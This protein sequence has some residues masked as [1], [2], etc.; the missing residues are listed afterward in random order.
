MIGIYDTTRAYRW[1]GEME[2]AG[3]GPHEGLRMPGSPLLVVANGGIHTHPDSARD[4]LNSATMEPSLA[5]ID[6]RD[7]RL[8]GL[9][10]LP[11][12]LHQVSIRHL[13]CADDGVVWFAGQYEGDSPFIHGLA[14]SLSV[15]EST[16]SFQAGQ[17]RQGLR[18][19]DVPADLQIRMSHYLSSVA[20]AGH[21]VVFTSAPGGLAFRVDRA[22]GL[23]EE[24]LSILDCSG[25]AA[26]PAE[27]GSDAGWYTL[28]SGALVTSGTGGI[29]RVSDDGIYSLAMH[30]LQWDNHVYRL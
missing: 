5:I 1:I 24:S 30:S 8:V 3:I 4:K 22:T 2:T 11:G 10:S 27:S 15:E 12:E 14:G 21:H 17:S 28:D 20:V 26:A 23:I 18:L 7:G 13:S 25:V 6:S 19:I 29:R 16:R 9:H